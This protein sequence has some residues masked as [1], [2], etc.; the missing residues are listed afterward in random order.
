[1]EEDRRRELADRRRREEA[2]VSTIQQ[3]NRPPT[4][5]IQPRITPPPNSNLPPPNQQ[6][7]KPSLPTQPKPTVMQR[8]DSSG[9]N[10]LQKV[11]PTGRP[12][13]R[14]RNAL[15]PL[16]SNNGPEIKQITHS[17]QKSHTFEVKLNKTGIDLGKQ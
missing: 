11:K 9:S 4:G 5:P 2:K 15:N 12:P 1:M 13:T 7:P 10:P 3:I 17:T 16:R 6:A 8:S 14:P